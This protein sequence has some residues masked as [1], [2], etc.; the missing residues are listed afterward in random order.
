[1]TIFMMGNTRI[2]L[3]VSAILITVFLLRIEVEN[4]YTR[5]ALRVTAKAD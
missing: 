3:R 1:M 4:G 5:K 2:M